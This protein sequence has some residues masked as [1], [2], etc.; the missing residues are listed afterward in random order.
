MKQPHPSDESSAVVVA[1]RATP[2]LIEALDAAA[3]AEGLCRAAYARRAALQSLRRKDA[4]SLPNG[5][6]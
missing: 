1:F 3:Q 4:L 6:G 5:E 2:Q